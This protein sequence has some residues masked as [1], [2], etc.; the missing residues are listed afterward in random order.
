MGSK[1]LLWRSSHT[2]AHPVVFSG[3]VLLVSLFDSGNV[4][5]V[6]VEESQQVSDFSVDS[7]VPHCISRRQLVGIGVESG[8]GFILISPTH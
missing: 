1:L 5:I 4:D 3:L 6:A 2:A 8:P 7:F